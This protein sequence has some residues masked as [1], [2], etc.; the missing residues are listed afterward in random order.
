M[1]CLQNPPILITPHYTP[2]DCKEE[3]DFAGATIGPNPLNQVIKAIYLLVRKIDP[4]TYG[5]TISLLKLSS[6]DPIIKI[7]K[8][9][10]TE[11]TE[12]NVRPTLPASTNVMKNKHG[13]TG[14]QWKR[15]G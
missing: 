12:D 13:R 5:S 10:Q 6:L 3:T 2:N 14:P 8:Q 7:T 15:A 11:N 9:P 1:G 4:S